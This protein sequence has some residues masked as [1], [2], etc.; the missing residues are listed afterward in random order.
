MCTSRLPKSHTPI[1][2]NGGRAF[3][4]TESILTLTESGKQEAGP[5]HS[6]VPQ[7]LRRA[8]APRQR[9]TGARPVRPNRTVHSLRDIRQKSDKA[10]RNR[11]VRSSTKMRQHTNSAHPALYI[12]PVSRQK[13]QAMFCTIDHVVSCRGPRC[14]R[15][16]APN[17]ITRP[18]GFR[19]RFYARPTPANSAKATTNGIA[20]SRPSM[21]SRMPPWPV[22]SSPESLTP[23]ARLNS[24]STRSPS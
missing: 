17:G 20:N 22:R 18:C 13:C 12:C 2:R 16:P 11:D 9:N 8:I 1:S 10:T 7:V 23:A 3:P 6:P 14:V 4:G 24:D 19:R 5:S 21:R 15:T